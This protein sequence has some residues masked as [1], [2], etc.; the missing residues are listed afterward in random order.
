MQNFKMFCFMFLFT[1]VA[2][3]NGWFKN[4]RKAVRKLY[5]KKSGQAPETLTVR[6]RWQLQKIGFL[7]DHIVPKFYTS[8]TGAVSIYHLFW[9]KLSTLFLIKTQFSLVND[10]NLLNISLSCPH[11][12]IPILIIILVFFMRLFCALCFLP[13]AAVFSVQ[14]K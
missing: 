2:K 11:I 5:K 3:V 9:L 10:M 14:D 7:K 8:D 1:A 12:L 4:Q 13:P 6:K